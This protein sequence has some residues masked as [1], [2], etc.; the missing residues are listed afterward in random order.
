MDAYLLRLLEKPGKSFGIQLMNNNDELLTHVSHRFFD[1]LLSR[2]YIVRESSRRV[3][4][5]SDLRFKK[6]VLYTI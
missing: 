5:A 1:P 3:P 4:R 2:G 6:Y